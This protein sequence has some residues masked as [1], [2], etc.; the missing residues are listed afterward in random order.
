MGDRIKTYQKVKELVL[1]GIASPSAILSQVPNV[2]NWRTAKKYIKNAINELS[3]SSK[4]ITQEEEYLIMIESLK[5]L[6]AN[7]LIRMENKSNINQY[8]GTLKYLI[9]INEQLSKLM[10]LEDGKPIDLDFNLSIS[11][12]K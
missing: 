4:F 1:K 3:D 7:L 5:S 10:R 6:K 8:L 12:V 9:K 2:K 11:V